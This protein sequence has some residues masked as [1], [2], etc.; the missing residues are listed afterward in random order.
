MHKRKFLKLLRLSTE[1]QVYEVRKKWKTNVSNSDFGENCMLVFFQK[2]QAC[3]S[4]G[5]FFMG[6]TI[7]C[8]R[9]DF[10]KLD[11]VRTEKQVSIAQKNRGLT[12][13]ISVW[14]KK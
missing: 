13:E 12:F 10:F 1:K 7:R 14:A 9:K 3:A 5:I 6:T 8:G 11:R 2:Q 4:E